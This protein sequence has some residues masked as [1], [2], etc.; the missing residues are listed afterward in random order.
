MNIILLK[1]FVTW[2]NILFISLVI[3][4]YLTVFPTFKPSQHFFFLTFSQSTFL[5]DFVKLLEAR[6]QI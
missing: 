3:K 6:V 2:K 1:K 5:K 4:I